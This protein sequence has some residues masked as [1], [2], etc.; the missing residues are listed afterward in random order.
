MTWLLVLLMFSMGG[1][2]IGS[3]LDW[4]LWHVSYNYIYSPRQFVVIATKVAFLLGSLVAA[5]A[6]LG[7]TVPANSRT[8]TVLGVT[9]LISAALVAVGAGLLGVGLAKWS[10]TGADSALAPRARVWF[11]EGL[12]IGALVGAVAST[13]VW[14]IL[15]FLRRSNQ[16]R[17]P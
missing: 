8:V 6:T 11:C 4:L 2:L 3:A 1:T 13:C 15:L 5:S 14:M 7:R 17:N 16:P 12:W 10:G 9:T